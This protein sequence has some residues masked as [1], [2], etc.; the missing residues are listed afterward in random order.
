MTMTMIT[1]D[2]NMIRDLIGVTRGVITSGGNSTP[3]NSNAGGAG[4]VG[5]VRK[6]QRCGCRYFSIT[7]AS[8]PR[9]I[10]HVRT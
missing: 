6:A 7:A 10:N 9:A 1:I 3:A 8:E 5:Y 4:D 2:G